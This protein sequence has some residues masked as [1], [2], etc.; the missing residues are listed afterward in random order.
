MKRLTIDLPKEVFKQLEKEAK[1][2]LRDVKNQVQFDL[3]QKY[4]NNNK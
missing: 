1:K 2:E 3:I 4:G